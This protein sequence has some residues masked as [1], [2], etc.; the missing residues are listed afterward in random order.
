MAG[1]VAA[2]LGRAIAIRRPLNAI[3]VMVVSTML[4]S[5]MMLGCICRCTAT[6][7]TS[8]TSQAAAAECRTYG[9][10]QAE[11]R[12]EKH[13]KHGNSRKVYEF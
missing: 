5:P 1:T 9:H 4:V 6:S 11:V 12:G 10:G 7:F 2:T 8:E 3:L 13:S